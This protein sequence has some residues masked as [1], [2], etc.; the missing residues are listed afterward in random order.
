[1][2]RWLFVH[3]SDELY[4]ADRVLLEVLSAMTADE[5]AQVSVWL[6]TD[7]GHGAF[8]LCDRLRPLGVRVE[9]VPLPIVRREYLTGPGLA[10]LLRRAEAFRRAVRRVNPDVVYGT[11]SATLLA[12]A[13]IG[14]CSRRRVSHQRPRVILHNQ[15]VWQGRQGTVL[16]MLAGNVDQVIAVSDAAARSLSL[17][18][19]S[20]ATVVPNS[21]PDPTLR[22]G[23][24]PLRDPVS[25]PLRFSGRRALDSA[26]GAEACRDR[27][28]GW[29]CPR[30]CHARR[31]C[32][33][34]RRCD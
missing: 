20:R 4:G 17:S 8:P 19:R 21:T 30:R 11:T 3:S 10:Q 25:K 26:K 27:C 12:L 6:P 14:W 34:I 33:T 31:W 22:A 32:A 9:H 13:A 1:M 5:R 15:E 29:D 23:F 18:L 16:G 24:V 7:T 2:T 28:L